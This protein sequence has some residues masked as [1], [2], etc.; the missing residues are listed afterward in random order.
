MR[1]TTLYKHARDVLPV[2]LTKFLQILPFFLA[3]LLKFGLVADLFNSPHR[4][5]PQPGFDQAEESQ[6]SLYSGVV[7]SLLQS[8]LDELRPQTPNMKDVEVK[9]KQLFK[10]LIPFMVESDLDSIIKIYE[11]QR[12]S[13]LKSFRDQAA[14]ADRILHNN[15]FQ[16]SDP[17]DSIDATACIL[18]Y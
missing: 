9:A 1:S 4:P 3:S 10:T 5:E 11:Q 12:A 13:I 2:S 6:L 16:A 17:M 7:S 14:K 18:S 15:Y 8:L